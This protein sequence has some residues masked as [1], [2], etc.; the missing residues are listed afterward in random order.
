MNR[1]DFIKH[2]NELIVEQSFSYPRDTK[3]FG[4]GAGMGRKLGLIRIGINY[5]ILRPRDCIGV[6][7]GTGHA[8]TH[9]NNTNKEGWL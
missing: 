7:P 4:I 5:E 6:P 3:T 9:I 2:I 8:H 1:P